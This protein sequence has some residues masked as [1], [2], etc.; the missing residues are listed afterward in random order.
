MKKARNPAGISRVLENAVNLSQ[1]RK[2]HSRIN[3][4][5]EARAKIDADI[6]AER[7]KLRD[8][9]RAAI[10]SAI[11]ESGLTLRE[12]LSTGSKR[13]PAKPRAKALYRDPS[14]HYNTWSGRG[15]H[16]KWLVDKL[17]AGE[18]LD[19]LRVKNPR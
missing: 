13:T 3:D 4:L 17:S 12:V 18:S 5:H 9:L 8:G 10:E 11:A 14:N 7:D 15:R 19:A 2:T 6:A 16:P 1:T